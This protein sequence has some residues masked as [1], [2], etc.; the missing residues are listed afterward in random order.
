VRVYSGEIKYSAMVEGDIPG[1]VKFHILRI[2]PGETIVATQKINNDEDPPRFGRTIRSAQ[3]R[4]FSTISDEMSKLLR[5]DN[6]EAESV[7][8][9]VKMGDIINV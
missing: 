2:G 3:L 1:K 5:N 9:W 8:K 4:L 7:T 6:D